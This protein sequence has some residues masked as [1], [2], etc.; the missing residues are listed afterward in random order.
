MAL[1]PCSKYFVKLVEQSTAIVIMEPS[2][3]SNNMTKATQGKHI[4]EG[5]KTTGPVNPA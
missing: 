5:G 4:I 2:S 1:L 3:D